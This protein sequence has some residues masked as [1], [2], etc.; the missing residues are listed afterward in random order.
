MKSI[1]IPFSI[2]APTKK[3]L[4][5]KMRQINIAYRGK[6]HFFDFTFAKGKWHCWFEVSDAARMELNVDK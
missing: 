1:N 5:D 6:I 3:G 4:T 2:D